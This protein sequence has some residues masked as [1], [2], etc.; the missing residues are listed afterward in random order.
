MPARQHEQRIAVGRRPRDDAAAALPPAP[1]FGSTTTLWP[2]SA[3][4]RSATTRAVTSALP[5][6]PKPCTRVMCVPAKPRRRY[7][8]KRQIQELRQRR[9]A[10]HGSRPY[11][12]CLP[13]DIQASL[14]RL[15][16]VFTASC[17]LSI[18]VA[19]HQRKKEFILAAA[20]G[21]PDGRAPTTSERSR[22]PANTARGRRDP[23]RH[24]P[25]PPESKSYGFNSTANAASSRTSAAPR[26]RAV[27]QQCGLRARVLT[28]R[29]RGHFAGAQ[30][31]FP[32]LVV[33]H[34][35]LSLS[36]AI[37]AC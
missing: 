9:R 16:S 21:E 1:G 6:A 10:S 4:R 25:I 32:S 31:G 17:I 27:R 15:H 22:C 29:L 37:R 11:G 12:Q 23:G 14:A 28:L 19:A 13:S 8:A 7:T 5:P 2:S 35:A 36:P 33:G 24:R 34:T 3:C 30:V 18:W 26:R 20:V